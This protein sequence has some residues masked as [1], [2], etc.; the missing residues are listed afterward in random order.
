MNII[1]PTTYF[2]P[3]NYFICLL[4]STNC[5]MEIYE[6]YIRHTTRNRTKILGGNGTFLLTVPIKKKSKTYIQD[7]KIIDSKWNREH[8]MSIRSAYGSTPFFI[9]YFDHIEKILN[10]KYDFLIDLN[11][12]ILN[13]FCTELSISTPIIKTNSY[14]KKYPDNY[15]DARYKIPL[16]KLEKKYTQIF[17]KNFIPNLSILDLI[18]NLGPEAKTYINN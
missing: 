8:I 16:N 5:Y 4:K 14:I 18:F 6:Y 10:K 9:H 13:F 1:L 12:E 3:I 17:S 7:V 2:P 11:D 15:L